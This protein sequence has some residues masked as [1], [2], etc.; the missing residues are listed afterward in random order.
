MPR[1][2]WPEDRRIPP[3]SGEPQGRTPAR[4]GAHQGS[5]VAG[6]GLKVCILGFE[7]RGLRLLQACPRLARSA[8][9]G[10]Q[11]ERHS[12]LWVPCTLFSGLSAACVTP[13][14][15]SCPPGGNPGEAVL[16]PL[17]PCPRLPTRPPHPDD[18]GW[19]SPGPK[20]VVE[21]GGPQMSWPCLPTPVRAAAF[22]KG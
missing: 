6:L 17:L 11:R 15:L 14:G 2:R 21:C 10:S 12:A 19:G 13:S 9:A 1:S 18:P 5:G 8:R 7:L 22:G 4:G 3:E 20:S 16:P